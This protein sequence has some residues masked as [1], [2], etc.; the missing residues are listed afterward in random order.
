MYP[1]R[2]RIVRYSRLSPE[3]EEL[4]QALARELRS[5]RVVARTRGLYPAAD[6]LVQYDLY[7]QS[8]YF[9]FTRD[10]L[11]G[12]TAGTLCAGL[13]ATFT[14]AI[15]SQLHAD[16]APAEPPAPPR[17]AGDDAWFAEMWNRT[18]HRGF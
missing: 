2:S 10:Q 18:L 17:D 12:V 5:G 1:R 8:V 3:H 13:E 11:H 16:A 6:L 15:L 4:V 9:T 14:A 7:G